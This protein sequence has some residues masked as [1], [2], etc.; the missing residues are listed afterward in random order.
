M[1][2]IA[3]IIVLIVLPVWQCLPEG[4]GCASVVDPSL[5]ILVYTL[6]HVVPLRL[7]LA[8]VASITV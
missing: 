3:C 7:R 6:F 2:K 5:L 4:E 8:I 1:D